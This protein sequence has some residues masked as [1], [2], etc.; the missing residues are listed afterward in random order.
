[1][2]TGQED[3]FYQMCMVLPS[4]IQKAV[5]SLE[6]VTIPNDTVIDELQKIALQNGAEDDDMAIAMAVYMLGFG[7]YKGF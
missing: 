6:H 2:V 7:G 1:M 3:A 5:D 4:V